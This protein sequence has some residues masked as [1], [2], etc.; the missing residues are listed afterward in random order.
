MEQRAAAPAAERDE[1]P[2]ASGDNFHTRDIAPV[3]PVPAD[4]GESDIEAPTTQTVDDVID[5]IGFG[6]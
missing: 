6:R 1:E 4:V 2:D 5:H 3:L